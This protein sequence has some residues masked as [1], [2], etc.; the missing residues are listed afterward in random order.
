MPVGLQLLGR[1]WDEASLLYVASVVESL[2]KDQQRAPRVLYDALAAAR[3][4]KPSLE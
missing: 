4:R 3:A 1:P 2:V